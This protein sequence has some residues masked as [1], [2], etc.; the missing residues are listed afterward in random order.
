VQT[1]QELAIAASGIH[2]SKSPAWAREKLRDAADS[3][4][5]RDLEFMEQASDAQKLLFRE[6]KQRIAPGARVSQATCGVHR[7]PTS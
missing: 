3:L 5:H 6:A 1:V 4:D 7:T 2:L